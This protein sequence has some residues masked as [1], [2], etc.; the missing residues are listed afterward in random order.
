ME[1]GEALSL[2]RTDIRIKDYEDVIRLAV[3]LA[4]DA[5]T[6]AAI[7]GPIASAVWDVPNE[8]SQPAIALLSDYG[9]NMGFRDRWEFSWKDFRKEDA[10]TEKSK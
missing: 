3:S 5:D 6:L 4:A 9:D 1:S 10:K 7:A 2:G 8:I